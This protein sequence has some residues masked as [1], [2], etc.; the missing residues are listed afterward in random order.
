MKCPGSKNPMMRGAQQVST[1]T[2][3][4]I[5]LAC[6]DRL[7]GRTG[8]DILEGSEDNDTVVWSASLDLGGV[9]R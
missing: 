4:V 5:G 1:E 6:N 2:E 3:L 9:F 7:D 8:N